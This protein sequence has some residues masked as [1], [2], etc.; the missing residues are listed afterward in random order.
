MFWCLV[1][2]FGYSCRYSEDVILVYDGRDSKSPLIA[3]LCNRESFV[4]IISSGPDLYIEF[5]T[6]SSPPIYNGFKASYRFES[7]QT[8]I[9]LMPPITTSTVA[10]VGKEIAQ[11]P[12][13][14]ISHFMSQLINLQFSAQQQN[15]MTISYTKTKPQNRREVSLQC[16]LIIDLY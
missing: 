1:L 6:G 14:G 12:Q 4:Q 5:K 9:Q 11:I 3:Q 8:N 7:N 16:I 10:P 15:R 2:D 13:T